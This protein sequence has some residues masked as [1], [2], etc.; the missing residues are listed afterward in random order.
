MTAHDHVDRTIGAW[1][2]SDALAPAPA[3]RLEQVIE[4]TRRR[5]PR[6][7][8][9]AGRGS[10]WVGQAPAT[11]PVGDTISVLRGWDIRWV[12][13]VVVL[14]AMVAI[15]GTAL[16]VGARLLTPAPS[17][18]HLAYALDDD[19]YV[20][21][22]D[23]T[24][25][26]RI[27][28]RT[29]AR[30]SQCTGYRVDGSMWSPDGRHL[31][32]RS[33]GEDGCVAMVYISDPDGH[34]VAS[35]PGS[36]WLVA[37]SPDSTR[38]TTWVEGDG[39]IGIFGLDGIRQALITL[40]TG[41]GTT[42]DYDPVWSPDGASLLLRLSSNMP[43][44]VWELPVDGSAARPVP[45]DDPRSHARAAFSRDGT[46]VAFIPYIT[47]ESLVIADA[48]GNE[49][50]VLPGAVNTPN[51]GPGEGAFHE[52]PVW[53]NAGDRIAF[54]W[55]LNHN[56]IEGPTELRVVDVDSG[57]ERTLVTGDENVRAIRWSSTDDRILYERDDASGA[58]SLWSV[59]AD[60]SDPRLLV[61]GTNEGDWR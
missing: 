39:R 6:P 38:V 15:A 44:V 8:W 31:A 29:S 27:T 49:I 61:T 45:D 1:F 19:I 58:S 30:G 32:Y 23:G 55:S 60:G 56:A 2:D 46:R 40:P 17:L 9:F 59:Q 24:N 5:K 41:L 42:G 35:F 52:S 53:S 37:W 12:T 18:E 28:D 25:A 20:G 22:W 34:V 57:V 43:S 36:G 33:G 48:H 13:V 21:E 51:Y 47:S 14:L 54:T 26:V 4:I 11:A 50:R 3:G 7:A 10:R 16:L